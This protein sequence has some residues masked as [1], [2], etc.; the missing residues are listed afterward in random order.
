MR[1]NKWGLLPIIGFVWVLFGSACAQNPHQQNLKFV[2]D[3]Q[4]VAASTALLNNKTALIPLQNLDQAKIASVH[5]LYSFATPFD[6]LLNKYTKVDSFNGRLYTS[7]TKTIANL[8]DD[9][10]LYT[11]IIMSLTEA[12][13][14]NQQLIAYINSTQKIKNFIIIVFGNGSSLQKLDA[15][16]API[17]WTEKVTPVSASFCAQA[18]FGGVAITQKLPKTFS[19]QYTANSGSTTIKTRLEYTVPEAAGV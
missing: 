16:N 14:A 7:D 4:Q 18:I 2:K 9:L 11:T 10:K 17:I 6:S 5:F 3:Q 15:I 13:M 12:D 19:Q 8:A 1:K